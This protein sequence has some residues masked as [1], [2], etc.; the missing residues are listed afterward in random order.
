MRKPLQETEG[1][2]R[3]HVQ[4]PHLCVQDLST[5][6]QDLSRV[7]LPHGYQARPNPSEAASTTSRR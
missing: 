3:P 1:P 5:H 6:H 7:R 4:V 2:G